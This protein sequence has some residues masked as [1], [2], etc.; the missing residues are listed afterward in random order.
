VRWIPAEA[1][2]LHGYNLCRF[3]TDYRSKETQLQL[4][5][6]G[7]DFLKNVE[8]FN[9]FVYKD[10]AGYQTIGYG[11]KLKSDERFRPGITEDRARVSC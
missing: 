5:E 7:L 2:Q 9:P 4:S 11:H 3:R 10:A 6:N 8:G 1:Q